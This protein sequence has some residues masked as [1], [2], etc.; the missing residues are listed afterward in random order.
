MGRLIRMVVLMSSAMAAAAL[1]VVLA[2]ATTDAQTSTSG[3]YDAAFY[4]QTGLIPAFPYRHCITRF[5]AYRIGPGPNSLGGGKYCF[6]IRVNSTCN[7]ACCSTDLD[8]IEFNVSDSCIVQP[9]AEVKA[10]INN[11]PTRVGA[12]FARPVN[13][14]TGSA[15]LRLTQLGLNLTTAADVRLCLTLKTNRYGMGCATLEQMCIPSRTAPIGACS[16][17]MIDTSST[18][19]PVSSS[20][21]PRRNLVKPPMP[22]PPSPPM[23]PPPSLSPPPPSPPPPPSRSSPPPPPPP[24]PMGDLDLCVFARL[25][26]PSNDVRP[27]QYSMV[28]C[29]NIQ[30]AFQDALWAVDLDGAVKSYGSIDSSRCRDREVSICGEAYNADGAGFFRDYVIMAAMP[31]LVEAADAGET[32]CKP[33]LQGYTVTVTAVG[34]SWQHSSSADCNSPFVPFPGSTCNA[35]QGILPFI[36]DTRFTAG[37][38]TADTTEYCF[39]VHVLPEDKLEPSTCGAANDNLAKIEWE[40]KQDANPSVVRGFNLYP[41]VG[42]S[43][44]L[45]PSWAAAGGSNILTAGP[46]NWTLAQ[47]NGGRVCIEVENTVTLFDICQSLPGQW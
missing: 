7:N 22:P 11:V 10:T 27:Y 35:M 38:V 16:V 5:G 37:T 18:C 2:A 15:V 42:A 14:R 12:A 21:T 45:S 40:A 1:A 36:V 6:R 19:C 39:T 33:E 29:L 23:P 46:L 4:E 25:Q 31:A 32:V 47:A 26:P 8:N 3:G 41:A 28:D 13:G 30:Q 9:S 43:S 17:A 34:K 44:K 24:T 20:S